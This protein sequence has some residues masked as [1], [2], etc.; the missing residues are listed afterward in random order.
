[1]SLMN[2]GT[3]ALV[4][5]SAASP[6]AE[7]TSSALLG[8]ELS[9]ELA[10]PHA[11]W[12]PDPRQQT[13]PAIAA[14]GGG[15][16][17]VWIA[18]GETT[19]AFGQ[20]HAARLDARGAVIDR[21]GIPIATL[22][23]TSAFRPAVAWDGTNFLV[24][25]SS[26]SAAIVGRYVSPDGQ[27]LST[28]LLFASSGSTAEDLRWPA[29]SCN[30]TDCLVAWWRFE[31]RTGHSVRL[32]RVSGGAIQQTDLP[33]I[34]ASSDQHEPA[35]SWNGTHYL[36]V[37]R[38]IRRPDGGDIYG[39]R[40]A[41]TGEVLDAEGFAISTGSGTERNASA[42]W[43]GSRWFVVW[44]DSRAGTEQL[45]GAR[46]TPA[47]VV[48]EPDGLVLSPPEAAHT[49]P[50]VTWNG[51][52]YLLVWWGGLGHI[53]AVRVDAAGAVVGG[54]LALGQNGVKPAR[55]VVATS[56]EDFVVAWESDLHGDPDIYAARVTAA[57]AVAPPGASYLASIISMEEQPAVASDG[58]DYFL[59]WTD[60]REGLRELGLYG[61]RVSG[62]GVVL[63]P[64]GIPVV[65]GRLS[66][67]GPAAIA[68]GGGV[69]LVVYGKPLYINESR[70]MGVRFGRDGTR[71]DA[72]PLEIG[73]SSSPDGGHPSLAWN[74]ID[75]FVVW[76]GTPS[77]H[78]ISGARVSPLGEVRDPTPIRISH[79]PA[80][81]LVR[82]P[83]VAWNGSIHLVAWEAVEDQLRGVTAVLGARVR[84]D[85]SV[86]DCA[87]LRLLGDN[88]VEPVLAGSPTGFL[89]AAHTDWSV[90]FLRFD[91]H[92][93]PL[94]TTPVRI[95]AGWAAAPSVSWDGASYLVAWARTSGP[96]LSDREIRAIRVGATGALIDTGPTILSDTFGVAWDWQTDGRIIRPAVASAGGGRS[97]VFYPKFAVSPSS[98]RM[99]ET[100]LFGRLL[101][102]APNGATCTAAEACSSGVCASGVCC[103]RAC[104]GACGAGSCSDPAPPP[105]ELP[106]GN[107]CGLP[108]CH[109]IFDGGCPS[110]DAGADPSP[111]DPDP[112]HGD[113][114]P[115]PC[116]CASSASPLALLALLLLGGLARRER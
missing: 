98:Q 74:G 54:P 86:H 46:V 58:T 76:D 1:M 110:L 70:V 43:N 39:A 106:R 56:G 104:S 73:R 69:Y 41:P 7:A 72:E 107:G 26:N 93:S 59:L 50:Q 13:Y 18:G 115:S 65:Q 24:V 61:T 77:G 90:D 97:A 99:R 15:Y 17:A 89:L 62:E 6:E 27:V 25:Y 75:F 52:H 57:G 16:L 31:T 64:T 48:E 87:D 30:G 36:V 112:P 44:Q 95:A 40:V 45:L 103:D 94:D 84:A 5:L 85:G 101:T 63:D 10:I 9:A 83:K 92:G 37:W 55:P 11:P 109:P 35:I 2:L 33:V 60:W 14:G 32:A 82:R 34:S 51:T 91:I 81:T 114:S 49:L 12:R 102:R 116:G 47:A 108:D 53:Y 23:T 19:S 79:S 28:E 42:T 21:Q 66:V 88:F 71:L 20:L 80:T 38:D 4:L 105:G 8:P 3:L 68:F 22:T 96:Y 29:V 113:E 100:H 67:S 78:G 111:G